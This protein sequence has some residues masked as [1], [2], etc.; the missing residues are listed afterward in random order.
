MGASP[1][2][3]QREKCPGITD[4][5]ECDKLQQCFWD[6]NKWNKSLSKCKAHRDRSL[7]G[8]EGILNAVHDNK[9]DDVVKIIEKNV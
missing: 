8:L 4:Q 5:K 2:Q 3:K 7:D 6:T 9:W 1:S